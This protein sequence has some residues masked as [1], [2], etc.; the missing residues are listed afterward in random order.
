MW[1]PFSTQKQFPIALGWAITIHKSQG[2]TL[3]KVN[4]NTGNNIF[5]SG[6]LYVALSRCK[7]I[8]GLCL[9]N[10]IIAKDVVI[11]PVIKDFYSMI[12]G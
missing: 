1:N 8:K 6:Q 3:N 2:M 7:S 12:N 9:S 4:V 5:A 10:K 11:D